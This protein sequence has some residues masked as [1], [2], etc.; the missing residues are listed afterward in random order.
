MNNDTQRERIM[1]GPSATYI[2]SI[3][4]HSVH[5]C[6]KRTSLLFLIQKRVVGGEKSPNFERVMKRE[7]SDLLKPFNKRTL[8]G[9][10]LLNVWMLV[11]V[12]LNNHLNHRNHD[13]EWCSWQIWPRNV[14]ADQWKGGYCA[15]RCPV[16]F[17]REQKKNEGQAINRIPTLTPLSLNLASMMV[18]R[19]QGGPWNPRFLP[20]HSMISI[21]G[22]MWRMDTFE[23][24]L[25]V[26][27][28]F[29]T[30]FPVQSV[31]RWPV[32]EWIH[33]RIAIKRK[34]IRISFCSDIDT[35]WERKMIW[36]VNYFLLGISPPWNRPI[37]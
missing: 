3:L 4:V 13:E 9:L 12:S 31:R 18:M 14:P 20:A 33:E 37:G 36:S 32:G 11:H 35:N 30:W 7:R 6:G 17:A 22:L 27:V 2:K 8:N 15:S 21:V 16:T 29:I 34:E 25:W 5:F 24:I 1:S 23:Q 28:P 10:I 19:F 26:L